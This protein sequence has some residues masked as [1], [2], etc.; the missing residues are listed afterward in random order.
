M[1]KNRSLWGGVSA[2][3]AVLAA[4]SWLVPSFH[5][6]SVQAQWAENS[7][8]TGDAAKQEGPEVAAVRRTAEAFAKAFNDGDAKA[9][10]ACWTPDCEYDGPV[11]EKIHGRAAIAKAYADYFKKMPKAHVDVQIH[12]IRLLGK[13]TALEEGSLKLYLPGDK[14]PGVSQYSVLHVRDTDGW[15]MAMVRE[16]IP[17]PNSLITLKDVAWLL[18]SWTA[19]SDEAELSIRYTWDEDKAYLR[20]RYILKRNGKVAASGTQVIGK[21]PGGGLRSWVFDASGSFGESVWLHD[22]GRWVI[23]A[24]G[25]LPDGSEITAVNILIPLGPDGF[26]WQ[27]VERS[28][29]GMALPEIAPV[30]VT[31]V[32]AAK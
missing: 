4:A 15:R 17:D 26:T 7:A 32:N 2:L 19:K 29:A 30:K 12:S 22:E 23:E 9:V 21:N 1:T 11:G 5:H 13:H 6:E 24:E 25:K 31:R 20:G 18:G 10:A 14:E 16:W 3:A 28:A 8:Q 27:S